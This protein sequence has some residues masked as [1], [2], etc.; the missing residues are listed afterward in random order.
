[1]KKSL[2][3]FNTAKLAKEKGFN[4]I[5]SSCFD[6]NGKQYDGMNHKNDLAN[7][8]FSAPTKEELKIWLLE[9]HNIEV[10]VSCY[11]E[12]DLYTDNA[13]LIKTYN[14]KVNNWNVKW[15]VHDGTGL[16]MPEHYNFSGDDY[17][18]VFEQGLYK[19]VELI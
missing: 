16:V 18:N 4:E 12:I 14:S 5:C 2:I 3:S 6:T 7:H 19:G 10:M 11:G 17:Y 9:N 1:M 13:P 8:V 15:S